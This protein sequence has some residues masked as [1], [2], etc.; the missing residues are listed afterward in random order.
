LLPF[1]ANKDV[2]IREHRNASHWLCKAPL[3]SS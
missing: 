2:Y 1:M 3:Y